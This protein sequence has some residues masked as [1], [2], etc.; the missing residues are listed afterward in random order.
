MSLCL[1]IMLCGCLLLSGGVSAQLAVREL[2]AQD[3]GGANRLMVSV[4]GQDTLYLSTL[5]DLQVYAPFVFK[6]KRQERF[7]WRTVRDVKKTLPYAKLI[8]R[9]MVKTNAELAKIPD[10]K[11]KKAF[12]DKHEKELF[13]LY[14]KTFTRMTIKQGAMLMKLVE[15]ECDR[16]SYDL[17][18]FYRGKVSAWFW[19]GIAKLFGNDLKVEYD[20]AD[21]DQIIERIIVLVENG[22]L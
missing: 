7:Y 11:G 14:K 22:Q 6:N 16:T 18:R 3:V 20:E 8:A 4:D 1:K 12:M 5:P 15:R 2:K 10:E 21:R 13:R 9:E 19:Q 17:I